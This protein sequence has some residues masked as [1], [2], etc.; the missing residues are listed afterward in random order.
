M[1]NLKKRMHGKM[2]LSLSVLDYEVTLLLYTLR[3]IFNKIGGGGGVSVLKSIFFFF[4]CL[5]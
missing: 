3:S 4:L 5:V 1:G 2:I